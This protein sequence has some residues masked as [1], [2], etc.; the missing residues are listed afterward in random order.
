[1]LSNLLA[2]AVS[3]FVHYLM[4]SKLIPCFEK[5]SVELLLCL[6]EPS[7]HCLCPI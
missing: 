1:M 3:R 6:T 7:E 4:E 5:V 2:V